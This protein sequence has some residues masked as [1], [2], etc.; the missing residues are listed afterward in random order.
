MTGKDDQHAFLRSL[1]AS[2][3][4]SREALAEGSER[5]LLAERWG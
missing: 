1:G 2:D 3:I 5:V 4:L